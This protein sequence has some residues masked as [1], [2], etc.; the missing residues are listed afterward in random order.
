MNTQRK[1]VQ[2]EKP[3][4]QAV[5]LPRKVPVNDT[6]IEGGIHYVVMGYEAVR[7]AATGRTRHIHWCLPA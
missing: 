1:P 2:N 5:V 4:Y 7:S 6:F 3:T